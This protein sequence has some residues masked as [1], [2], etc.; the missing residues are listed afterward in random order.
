MTN[1]PPAAD[2]DHRLA[3][4]ERS[5]VAHAPL[6]IAVSGGVDSMTLATFAGR[7]LPSRQLRMVH[8]SSPAVPRAAHARVL[9]AAAAESW[10]LYIV[11]AGELADPNYRANPINRC[12]FCKSNL[13]RT[14]SSLADGDIASGTNCD[15]LSDY[16]PG[17]EAA[18][19]HDVCH[20]YVEAGMTKSDVRALARSMGLDLLA[21][22]P[23]SPCLSSRVETGLMIKANDLQ[24]ID[25]IESWLWKEVQ[26]D[27]ARC[28]IRNH[29]IVLEIDESS[30]MRLSSLDRATLLAKLRSECA[31]VSARSIRFE[32]YRQ[33]SA[34]V[35]DRSTGNTPGTP[36]S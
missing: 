4:L 33:G 25:R 26:P 11:D 22:M 18:A 36:S 14:L 8:A 12:F 15:D 2:L 32:S 27:I 35:G 13:Y 34:F 16:R 20:P 28:R 6:T 7:I 5:I 1:E 17:L 31:E 10:Q 29:G 30:L 24:L 9:E 23:A 21:E 3:A 19:N